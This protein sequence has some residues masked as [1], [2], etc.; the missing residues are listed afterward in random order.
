MTDNEKTIEALSADDWK[1]VL[2]EGIH[3][4]FR[5]GS[6]H[7]KAH[8]Y[9]ELIRDMPNE[10]WDDVLGYVVW[11]LQYMKLIEVSE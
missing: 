1:S 4:A 8:E 5:K 6:D 3:V 9:W 2:G 10:L 11:S 7:E